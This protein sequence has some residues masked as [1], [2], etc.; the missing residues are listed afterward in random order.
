MQKPR[1][2]GCVLLRAVKQ[3]FEHAVVC[4][5]ELLGLFLLLTM[6]IQLVDPKPEP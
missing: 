1:P 2:L 4:H 6:L 5:T 3:F